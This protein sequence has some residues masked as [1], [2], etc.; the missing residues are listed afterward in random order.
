MP[1]QALD[2]VTNLTVLSDPGT[3]SL[4]VVVWN[5]QV[6]PRHHLLQNLASVPDHT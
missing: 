1:S 4:G 3:K 5:I 2:E 6:L